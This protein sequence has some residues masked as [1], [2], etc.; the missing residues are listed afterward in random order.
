MSHSLRVFWLGW[1]AGWA[2]ILTGLVVVLTFGI[3]YPQW[4]YH[5]ERAYIAALGEEV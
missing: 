2:N 1:V 4:A 5:A 3:C